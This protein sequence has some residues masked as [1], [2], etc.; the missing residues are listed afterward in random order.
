[1][2]KFPAYFLFGAATSSHQ[3]EGSCNNDWSRWEIANASRLAK[4]YSRTTGLCSA[5]HLRQE[6]IRPGNYISGIC[7]DH[8]HLFEEDFRLAEKIGLNACRF[9]V[10]WSR[11]EP[12]EGVWN[13]NELKHYVSMVSSLRKKNIEPFVT[14]WHWTLPLWLAD[15]GGVLCPEFPFYFSRYAAKIVSA[16]ND[17][18]S[19]YIIINEPEIYSLNSYMLGKWTPCK[20]GPLNYYRSITTLIRAHTLAYSEMKKVNP[21]IKAGTACNMTYFEPGGGFINRLAARAADRWW[22][23]Y[24]TDKVM[25]SMDFMGLNYYF[26]NRIHYGLN[27]NSNERISDMGWELYPE[28]IYHVLKNLEPYGLPV[29]VTES[30]LADA[31]DSRRAWLIEETLKQVHKA[32]S[33]G[34]NVRGYLHWS[35]LDNFE[36]DKGFWPRFGLISVD[37]ATMKRTMRESAKVYKNIIQ[38]GLNI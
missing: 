21:G 33:E 30:G 31:D 18:A 14:I 4:E 34:V 8:Y 38:N 24:F 3:V 13:M 23:R 12:E 11:V 17:R 29:Y 35:L 20:K 25:G 22:N 9:S 19:Y 15:R 26:H 1:M 10:E 16:M 5:E 2:Q 6:G 32:L 28:G 27:R 36:W 37:H 7:V